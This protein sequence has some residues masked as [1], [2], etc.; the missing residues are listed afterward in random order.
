MDIA[1][2]LLRRDKALA[3]REGTTLRALT[4]EGLRA[5]LPRREKPRRKKKIRPVTVK[6][7]GLTPEAERMSWSEIR[8]LAYE[9]PLDGGRREDR[10]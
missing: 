1:D 2:D 5:V 6:G 10:D 4:E 7:R 3:R 8:S 9:R